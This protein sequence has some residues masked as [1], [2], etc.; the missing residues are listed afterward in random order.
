MNVASSLIVQSMLK[1]RNPA[2]TSTNEQWQTVQ[3]EDQQDKELLGVF[4]KIL[5][6]VT[7]VHDLSRSEAPERTQNGR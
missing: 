1:I 3:E 4:N 2:T 7:E 5:A 6:L